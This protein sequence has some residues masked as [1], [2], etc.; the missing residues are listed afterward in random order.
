MLTRC[1]RLG[2]LVLLTVPL[3]AA[4]PQAEIQARKVMNEFMTTFNS[5]DL[6]AWAATL[7][8]PHVRLASNTVKV[9]NS[10]TEY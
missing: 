9:Y 8:F 7:N 6:N 5:G 1:V 4:D 2:V 3:Y 10:A